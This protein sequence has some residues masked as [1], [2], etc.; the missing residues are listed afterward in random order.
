YFGLELASIKGAY[1]AE[2]RLDQA[3]GPLLGTV[4]LQDRQLGINQGIAECFLR[5]AKGE[6]EVFLVLVPES[7]E[8]SSL[9]FSNARFFAGAPQ[10]RALKEL[11]R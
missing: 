8:K 6:R 11:K 3:D 9:R 2:V 1:R 10:A 7:L 5:G 4:T